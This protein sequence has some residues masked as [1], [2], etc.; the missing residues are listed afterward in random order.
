MAT[1]TKTESSE[2]ISTPRALFRQPLALQWLEDGKLMKR[3]E[4]ER[5]AGR[6]EL[7]LD[8]LYV[9]ILANFAENLADDVSGVNLVKYILILTPT[10]HVWS[11]LRELMN[12]FYT[13]DLAQRVLILWIM[14]LLVIY[15]NNATY[16]NEDIS[17]M[18]AT[19]GAYMIARMSATTT[20][21]LY[22]FASYHHRAQQRLW[23]CLSIVGLCI[24]IPLFVESISLRSKIAVA[25]VG[26]I[27]EESIWVFCYAPAAKKLLRARYT[28]A[29]D[30]PHEIDR[31]AAFFIIVLG[32]FLYSIVVGSPAAIG[33]NDRLL[34]AIW[35]LIIAFCLNWLYVH[36]DGAMKGVH[37][38]R[39]SV[40]AA[41]LWVVLH[42]PLV[43]SLLA[44]G[45]VAAIC[46][47]SSELQVGQVWLL[48][49]GI[50][51]GLIILYLVALLH[52]S[53]DGSGTLLLPKPARLVFRP[54]SGIIIIC[55]PLAHDLG[56][57]SIVSIV[58]AL[59]VLCVVWENITSLISGAKFWEKW[60]D[61]K[62]PEINDVTTQP[63]DLCGSHDG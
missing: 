38:L 28:T 13:D 48:C 2:L 60:V 36:N 24:Y 29:V 21:L 52:K 61:T 54:V 58:M 56:I 20:H 22:S 16:V 25:S 3:S 5:Q 59:S 1:I 9:A 12:S 35:T 31:F 42:L 30:I 18:R 55:L 11:D 62:Y 40:Y 37:P 33:F 7:F 34:R 49:G 26:I 27:V 46:A 47:R 4:A 32:E 6:F 15:G 17:A 43:A 53:E 63:Q 19:V 51:A 50:G 41:F 8:L 45:H 39:H 44:G 23:F 14:V 57:T 10:W